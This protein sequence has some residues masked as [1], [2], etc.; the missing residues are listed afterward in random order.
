MS[1]LVTFKYKTK[2]EKKSILFRS[3]I[4]IFERRLH[5]RSFEDLQIKIYIVDLHSN[6]HTMAHK[7]AAL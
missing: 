7:M 6:F 3:E 1:N 5:E 2:F 4:G